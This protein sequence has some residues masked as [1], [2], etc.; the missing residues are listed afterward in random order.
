MSNR[1]GI[2]YP[3]VNIGISDKNVH[4]IY[5]KCTRVG[6]TLTSTLLQRS[7]VLAA[8]SLPVAMFM[9]KEA[10]SVFYRSSLLLGCRLRDRI[11][12]LALLIPR[13]TLFPEARLVLHSHRM[14]M[15]CTLLHVT[16]CCY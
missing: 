3:R 4:N 15:P 9:K 13:S 7:L 6:S 11:L 2:K 10:L 1:S 12:S 16:F 5:N 14:A 8:V